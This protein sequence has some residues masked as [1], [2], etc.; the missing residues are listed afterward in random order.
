M[1]DLNLNWELYVTDLCEATFAREL[2]KR[3]L[4]YCK[5]LRWSSEAKSFDPEE[6]GDLI[7]F[8]T[9]KGSQAAVIGFEQGV[10]LV[11]LSEGEVLARIAADEQEIGHV[12][13]SLHV[14]LPIYEIGEEQRVHVTFW[15]IFREGA[16]RSSRRITAPSWQEIEPNYPRATRRELKPLVEGF[17]PGSAGQLVLWHGKPGTGK[18]SA[19]RALAWEWREWCSFEYVIDPENLFKQPNYLLDVLTRESE[20]DDE[21]LNDDKWRLLAL[22]D[23]GELLAVDAKEQTGQGLSRLLN[24]VDGL[25]GQGLKILILVTTN[26]PLQALH[27]AVSRPGRCAAEIEFLPF[28]TDE[29][30]VWLSGKGLDPEAEAR[31]LAELFASADAHPKPKRRT[32]GF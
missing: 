23:T 1:D 11:S 28:P 6:L 13:K 4:K 17:R 12:V 8:E 16:R 22:E 15:R 27:P 25:L 14:A 21:D 9:D 26:E 19:L 3:G 29:A 5:T 10:A 7:S 20:D 32:I 31:T 30:K 24:V 18:T 2:V